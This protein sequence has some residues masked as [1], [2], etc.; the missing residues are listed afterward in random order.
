LNL[1]YTSVQFTRPQFGIEFSFE[2]FDVNIGD[3]NDGGTLNTV[4]AGALA[5][6]FY[7]KGHPGTT[8]NQ[9]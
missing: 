5:G 7:N 4:Q 1:I 3:Y 6:P 9:R 8:H 2:Q